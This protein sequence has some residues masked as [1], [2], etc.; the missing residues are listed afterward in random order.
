MGAVQSSLGSQQGLI[1][2]LNR[3]MLSVRPTQNVSP[4][5]IM[6]VSCILLSVVVVTVSTVLL[7]RRYRQ[8]K[9]YQLEIEK[10]IKAL[11]QAESGLT[12]EE[13][14]MKDCC[15]EEYLDIDSCNEDSLTLQS[16]EVPEDEE[17]D[18]EEDSKY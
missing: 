2:T 7:A 8:G 18:I 3:G 11:E 4:H 17:E 10:E 15:T 13:G 6:G 1:E 12:G 14:V 16:D 9:A 5:I